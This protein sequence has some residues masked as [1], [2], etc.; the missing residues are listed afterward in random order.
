[1]IESLAG[2][3]LD[4]VGEV[5]AEDGGIGA[6]GQGDI[7]VLASL[8]VSRD[9][10]RNLRVLLSCTLLKPKV[11]PRASQAVALPSSAAVASPAVD[12]AGK[13]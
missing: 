1:V 2:V 10:R 7:A 11:S 3:L 9:E 4:F 13:S 12:S 6:L 8:Q 5:G